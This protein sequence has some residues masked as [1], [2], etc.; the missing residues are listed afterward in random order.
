MTKAA[1][2]AAEGG[3]R[4]SAWGRTVSNHITLKLRLHGRTALS[5]LVSKHGDPNKA[6]WLRKSKIVGERAVDSLSKSES[7]LHLEQREVA[8]VS[9]ECHVVHDERGLGPTRTTVPTTLN[10]PGMSGDLLV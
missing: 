7:R 8:G 9:L 3:Q 10:P 4:G 5:L 6:V 2:G 1:V